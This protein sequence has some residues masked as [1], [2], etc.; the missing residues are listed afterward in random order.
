MERQ[1][2]LGLMSSLR[3]AGAFGS[4]NEAAGKT[5]PVVKAGDASILRAVLV[6]CAEWV[7]GI[8][9]AVLVWLML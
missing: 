6:L 8:L 7:G 5:M 1:R 2:Y 3:R 9:I 4:E